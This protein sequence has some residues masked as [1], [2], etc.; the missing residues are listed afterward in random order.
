MGGQ[1]HTYP[2]HAEI[3]G[4]MTVPAVIYINGT[5]GIY[6]IGV[7]ISGMSAGVA[8]HNSDGHAYYFPYGHRASATGRSPPV[9][10]AAK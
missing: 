3:A 4:T 7:T 8:V 6:S 5:P 10:S 1:N 2:V 9:L